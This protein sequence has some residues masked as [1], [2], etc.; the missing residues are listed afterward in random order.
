MRTD[1]GWGDHPASRCAPEEPRRSPASVPLLRAVSARR[2][3]RRPGSDIRD[4]SRRRVSR[5]TPSGV[6]SNARLARRHGADAA[7]PFLKDYIDTR[8]RRLTTEDP[9]L[10]DLDHWWDELVDPDSQLPTSG[11]ASRFHR[12]KIAFRIDRCLL[13][14]VMAPLGDPEISFLVC[15]YGDTANVEA[16]NSNF[17]YTC[18]LTLVKGDPYCDKCIH[19]GRFVDAIEHPGRSFYDGLGEGQ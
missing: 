13:H 17:T 18:P 10:R 2:I 6:L 19:D 1:A 3:G 8:T 11:I 16:I 4:R 14:E 5:T 7:I 9:S 12:G 15:C